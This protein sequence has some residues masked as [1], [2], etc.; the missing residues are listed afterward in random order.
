MGEGLS[1]G[2]GTGA[3]AWERGSGC[4][5][6]DFLQLARHAEL[7]RDRDDHSV[8][9]GSDGRQ[10]VFQLKEITISKRDCTPSETI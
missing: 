3:M 9:E 10:V 4:A 7:H 8:N 2:S 5:G 1:A 6:G